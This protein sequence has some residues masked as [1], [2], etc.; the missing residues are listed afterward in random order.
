[1]KSNMDRF[2][3]RVLYSFYNLIYLSGLPIYATVELLVQRPLY[4]LPFWRRRLKEKYGIDTFNE[5]KD[6]VMGMLY[7]SINHPAT[8]FTQYYLSGLALLL[9]ALPIYLVI[10]IFII[11]YGPQAF[12]IVGRHLIIV[13]ASGIVPSW[14]ICE[15]LYWKNNRYLNYF[16]AFEKESKKTKIAW[17]IGTTLTLCLLILANFMLMW[18]YDFLYN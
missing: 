2:L 13:V 9:F 11:C 4:S 14:I 3:N 7:K 6:R 15:L 18:C 12:D 10:N 17:T 8:G 1:M 16:A 5:Y